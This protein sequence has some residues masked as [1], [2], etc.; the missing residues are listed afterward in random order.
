[1]PW[2]PF[3]GFCTS[4]GELAFMTVSNANE[5]ERLSAAKLPRRDWILLSLLSL[6]TICLTVTSWE[7]MARRIFPQS[8]LGIYDCILDGEVPVRLRAIPNSVC[9]YNNHDTPITEYRMN[10]CGHRAGME[11]GTKSG[12][13]YRI[14]MVGSSFAVGEGVP[15]ENTVASLLPKD[16]S[17]RTGRRVDL[18][19]EGMYMEHPYVIAQYLKE[20][21]AEQPDMILWFLTPHDLTNSLKTGDTFDSS[22]RAPMGILNRGWERVK[23]LFATES[24]PEAMAS[25]WTLMLHKAGS[26]ASAL[27]LQ[28]ILWGNQIQYIESY[29][30]SGSD[31]GFLKNEPDATWQGYIKQFEIDE[32]AVKAQATAEGVPLVVVL[33]PNRAQAA[34]LSTGYSQNGFSPYTLD[35]K[36]RSMVERDGGIYI[37]ILPHFRDIPHAG[38]YYFP[39]NGHPNVRGTAII[40][41][42]LASELT[43]GAIPALSV[44]A[45]TL[46]MQERGR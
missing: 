39:V 21:M 9:W 10:R 8:A 40:A 30:E 36:L 45:Q 6:L 46:E 32:E 43:H 34:M 26:S 35:G 22:P 24:I 37:D 3:T 42:F 16:L 19:N 28:H 11:C 41:E 44:A 1:M 13:T 38:E 20:V 5:P 4:Q 18:Y 23:E 15:I 27:L 25:A 14:V 2:C 31:A 29:L 7:W 17:Q 33:V 12:G